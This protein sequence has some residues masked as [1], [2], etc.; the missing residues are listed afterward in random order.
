MQVWG[1]HSCPPP[2]TLILVMQNKFETFILVIQSQFETLATSN[3]IANK[4]QLQKRRTAVS[5]PHKKAGAGF[6][7]ALK[8]L[9]LR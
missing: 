8:L 6:A 4:K 9:N 5:A 7:G 3:N 2:L 1:G